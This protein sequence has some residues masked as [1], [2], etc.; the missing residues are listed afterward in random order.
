DLLKLFVEPDKTGQGYGAALFEWATCEGRRLGASRMTIEA[1]PDAEPFYRKQGARVVG[2]AP[3][4]S[5]P[6]RRLPLLELQLK[7]NID[8]S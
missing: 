5:I 6:G 2:T 7:E 4:G 1:D 3:S 8:N